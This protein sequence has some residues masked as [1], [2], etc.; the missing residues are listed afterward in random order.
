[1]RGVDIE[2]E[3]LLAHLEE[4]PAPSQIRLTKPFDA[5]ARHPPGGRSSSTGDLADAT[6]GASSYLGC[7]V[8]KRSRTW[9]R[10]SHTKPGVES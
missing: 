2:G 4:A 8:E 6:P 3:K 9:L 10:R 5:T 7:V 1:M